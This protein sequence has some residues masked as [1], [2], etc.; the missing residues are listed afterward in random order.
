M[1]FLLSVLPPTCA[2]SGR[3]GE[4]LATF[5]PSLTFVSRFMELCL[6]LNEF[7]LLRLTAVMWHKTLVSCSSV[8]LDFLDYLWKP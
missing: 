7:V 6:F 8:S 3:G 1:S 4:A 5:S 2:A